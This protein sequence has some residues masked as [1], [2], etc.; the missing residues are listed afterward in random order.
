MGPSI[1]DILISQRKTPILGRGL[2]VRGQ[3]LTFLPQTHQ[4]VQSGPRN[5]YTIVRRELLPFRRWHYGSAET[6][7]LPMAYFVSSVM[8]WGPASPRCAGGSPWLGAF[9]SARKCF[10]D[11]AY[12]AERAMNGYLV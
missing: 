5:G 4:V 1:G 9:G 12:N 7:P 8:M 11:C 6:I 2:L 10:R 3:D